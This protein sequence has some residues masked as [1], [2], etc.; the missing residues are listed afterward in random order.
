MSD[1][2]SSKVKVQFHKDTANPLSCG[3]YMCVTGCCQLPYVHIHFIGTVAHTHTH[4][5]G[6]V[7][8]HALAKQAEESGAAFSPGGK[9]NVV[10][11]RL[12]W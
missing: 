6:I 3:V 1:I 10:A 7:L 5:R 11:N 4:T 2:V 9:R 12:Q 8:G